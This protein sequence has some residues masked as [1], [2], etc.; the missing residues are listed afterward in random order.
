[1]KKRK[2][3]DTRLTPP[4]RVADQAVAEGL[5]VVNLS[6]EPIAID[7][8]A[9]AILGDLNSQAGTAGSPL[10]PEILTRLGTLGA[11][12]AR[13]TEIHLSAGNREYTC[14]AFLVDSCNGTITQPVLALHLKREAS[15]I[16]DV[17]KL[18]AKYHL[19][20]R[21]QQVLLGISRGLTSKQLAARMSISPNTVK[22]FLRMIMIKMGVTTRTGIVGKLLEHNDEDK[23]RGANAGS[24][25]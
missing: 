5:V 24:H 16:D 21:E 1:M 14:T 23:S 15:L 19:T 11:D 20:D 3:E 9:E 7:A 17:N 22:A 12:K 18:A 10:P 4:G 25:S 2:T 13:S 6:Y 8:G